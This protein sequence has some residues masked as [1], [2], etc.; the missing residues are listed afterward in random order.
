[1]YCTLYRMESGSVHIKAD[2]RRWKGKEKK[3]KEGKERK[4]RVFY[5]APFIPRIVSI[6]DYAWYKWCYIKNC[7]IHVSALW[8]SHG[9][10]CYLQITPRLHFFRKRSPDGATPEVA[11]IQLQ[12]TSLLIFKKQIHLVGMTIQLKIHQSQPNIYAVFWRFDLITRSSEEAGTQFFR[13]LMRRSTA[14]A[15]RKWS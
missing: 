4:G 5:M 8:N 7:V 3:G 2:L 6:W 15:L 11:H 12:L 9:S 10:Q 1:M 13:V 14:V